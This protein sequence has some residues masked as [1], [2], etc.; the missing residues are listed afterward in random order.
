MKNLIRNLTL[1]AAALVAAL[2]M[3]PKSEAREI[4]RFARPGGHV[5]VHAPRRVYVAPRFYTP[6]RHAVPFR[7][8]SGVRFYGTCPGPGYVFV[9]GGWALPPFAS[10]VWVPAHY[11]RFGIRTGGHWR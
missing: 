8:V 2:V 11:D 5:R 7:V 10:A 6:L 3:A 1:S 9:D 4:A